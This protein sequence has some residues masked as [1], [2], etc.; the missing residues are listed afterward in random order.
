MP[1]FYR[2]Y[3]IALAFLNNE[4]WPEA[5]ALFQRATIYTKKANNEKTL[6]GISKLVTQIF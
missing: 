2:C 4:K 1:S 5:M 3:Y 6:P